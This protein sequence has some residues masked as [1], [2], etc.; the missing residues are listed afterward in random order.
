MRSFKS[1]AVPFV[2]SLVFAVNAAAGAEDIHIDAAHS[3]AQFSVNHVMIERVNG[4][5][6][7]IAG[8]ISV[9]ADGVTP[10]AVSATLD[11]RHVATGD[12]DR[13]G[14]LI[15]SDWFD[16]KRFP[17]WTFTSTGVT[18]GA[19]GTFNIA[20]LLTVHGVAVPVTLAATV[21]PHHGYRAVTHVDR[22]AFGMKVGRTDSLIGTDVTISLDIQTAK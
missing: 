2:A 11:A 22:H 21:V 18:P 16:T 4:S 15:G 1:Y 12:P 19:A 6:P 17:T 9:G 10:T 8:T 14:D 5:I 20:G 3:K 13:D 7:V